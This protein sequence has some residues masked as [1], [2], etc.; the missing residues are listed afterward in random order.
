MDTKALQE[1][2][3]EIKNKIKEQHPN[4][5]DN[6]LVYEIGKEVELL[7]RL[8]EKLGKNSKEIKEW[9]SLMG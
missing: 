2:W 1:K 9:L 5:S 6:D 7:H 4:I 3:P 8:Q